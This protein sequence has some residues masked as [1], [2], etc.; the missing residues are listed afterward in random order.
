MSISVAENSAPGDQDHLHGD[1]DA[2]FTVAEEASPADHPSEGFFE[3]P[4]ARQN[5]N[6]FFGPRLGEQIP[7]P[8]L[9]LAEGG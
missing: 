2:A 1:V 6:A 9:A 8:R 7:H 3:D 4:L 5:L